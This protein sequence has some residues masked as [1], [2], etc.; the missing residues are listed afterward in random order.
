MQRQ[1][2]GVSRQIRMVGEREVFMNI[3]Y[4]KNGEFR[5]CE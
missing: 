1:E 5:C 3:M 4:E 2:Q